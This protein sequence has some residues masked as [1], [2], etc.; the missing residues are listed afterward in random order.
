[1]SWDIY[2]HLK[3]KSPTVAT[4]TFVHDGKEIGSVDVDSNRHARADFAFVELIK[5]PTKWRNL[6]T[7][8]H[9]AL[10]VYREETLADVEYHSKT[11]RFVNT[12]EP[13]GTRWKLTTDKSDLHQTKD[14]QLSLA[15]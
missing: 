1:M 5:Q 15:L 7:E 13:I 12:S 11:Y 3:S 6:P 14:V 9:R 10:L 4:A 8:L 2:C